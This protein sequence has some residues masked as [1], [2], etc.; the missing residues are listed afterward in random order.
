MK[1]GCPFVDG[2]IHFFYQLGDARGGLITSA[3]VPI[4][5]LR[6][7]IQHLHATIVLRQ[8]VE[9]MTEN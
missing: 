5:N 2:S 3:V 1:I 4:V 7:S 9:V 6:N 8:D